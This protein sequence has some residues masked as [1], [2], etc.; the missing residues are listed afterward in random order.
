MGLPKGFP[1][2]LQSKSQA[3]D[4]RAS[5]SL[6]PTMPPALSWDAYLFLDC[7]L[8]LGLLPQ[9]SP[10]LPLLAF[11]RSWWVS[12]RPLPQQYRDPISSRAN[13][14]HCS[15]WLV[16]TTMNSPFPNSCGMRLGFPTEL[17][18]KP[19]LSFTPTITCKTSALIFV[20]Y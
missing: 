11:S 18:N 20:L 1:S 4:P 15:K 5:P 19:V 10:L 3:A 2:S 14:L 8:H 17:R 16:H 6:M 7:L 12:A 9:T 13:P